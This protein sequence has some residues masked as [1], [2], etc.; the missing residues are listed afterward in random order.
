MEWCERS[1][2]ECLDLLDAFDGGSREELY[3]PH[4][5]HW[6]AKGHET[7]AGA[8]EPLVRRLLRR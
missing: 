3:F 6:T 1:G 7:A 4:D 8:I 5:L 2:T